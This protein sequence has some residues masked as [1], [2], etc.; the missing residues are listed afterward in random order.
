MR[1]VDQ[2]LIGGVGVHSR[3]QAAFESELFVQ[4]HRQ[5]RGTI[6]RATGTTDDRA[7]LGNHM[8]IDPHHERRLQRVLGRYGDQHALGA[9]LEV[10]GQFFQLTKLA[11]AFD[12]VVNP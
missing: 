12:H 9:G 8:I 3:Q 4:H 1:R 6:G 2:P 10:P 5:W 11:A 7:V